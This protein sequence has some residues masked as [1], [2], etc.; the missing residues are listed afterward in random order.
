MQPQLKNQDSLHIYIDFSGCIDF[1]KMGLIKKSN[2]VSGW[3]Y[4][5]VEFL[6]QPIQVITMG[7]YTLSHG[8]LHDRGYSDI[9]Y[10]INSL[11]IM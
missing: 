3:F 5:C 6:R 11:Y 9:L 10:R 2:K 1:E 4:G 8:K 7:F